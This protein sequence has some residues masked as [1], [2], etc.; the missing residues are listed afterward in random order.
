MEYI[1]QKDFNTIESRLVRFFTFCQDVLEQ[2]KVR[3]EISRLINQVNQITLK[4]HKRAFLEVFNEDSESI[5]QSGCTSTDWI[6]NDVYL[7]YLYSGEVKY[8]IDLSSVY[9]TAC[10]WSNSNE[11]KF[12]KYPSLSEE[13]KYELMYSKI[14]LYLLYSCFEF[15]CSP[16]DRKQI[17]N[18]I[19]ELLKTIK[20]EKTT[21]ANPLNMGEAG[22][23]ISSI[24]N[25]AKEDKRL[26]KFFSQNNIQL[27][28]LV[29]NITSSLANG[30]G[31]MVSM[32]KSV[33]SS[34]NIDEVEDDEDGDGN[35]KESSSSSSSTTDEK[36]EIKF[37]QEIKS[38]QDYSNTDEPE[39][40]DL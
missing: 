26:G 1:S 22:K 37:D 40:F 29:N 8:S 15:F 31:D 27:D 6:Q 10:K 9:R 21:E 3:N 7:E 5:L 36:E 11:K 17:R 32:F 25:V 12:K 4:R 19:E 14:F 33:L 24:V 23:M 28:S 30:N 18:N 16:N 38:K 20:S 13:K 39:V 34:V 35:G 2:F